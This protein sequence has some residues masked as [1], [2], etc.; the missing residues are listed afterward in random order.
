MID[1]TNHRLPF[2]RARIYEPKPAT[3][4]QN[5]TD[6]DLALILNIWRHELGLPPI[7]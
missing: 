1:E 7:C 5:F 3:P 2:P 6:E 4:L